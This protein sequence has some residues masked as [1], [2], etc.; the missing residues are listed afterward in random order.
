[1]IIGALFILYSSFPQII[2]LAENGT[3]LAI[4]L[5]VLISLGV[6]Y[7]LGSAD[8]PEERTDLTLCTVCRHPGTALAVA[9]INFPEQKLSL[10]Q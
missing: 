7:T 2:S 3:V 1:M 10:R 8:S 9:N 6:G 4:L 5:F